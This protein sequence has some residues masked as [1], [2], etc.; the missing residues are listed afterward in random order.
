MK[1]QRL[2]T[3]DV[4][5][6]V[7]CILI[8]W[9]FFYSTLKNLHMHWQVLSM[10]CPLSIET[11][12]RIDKCPKN[13]LDWNDRAKKK[14]CS[15]IKQDCTRKGNFKY[16]CV[17]NGDGTYLVEVCAPFKYIHGKYREIEPRIYSFLKQC[18][19]FDNKLNNKR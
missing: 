7:K 9:I 17:L 19:V 15:S 12:K 4:S 13:I 10:Q 11:V 14:N 2:E 18:I 16:H 1:F 8:Y 3:F 6:S 5:L